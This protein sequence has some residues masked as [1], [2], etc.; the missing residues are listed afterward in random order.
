MTVVE[1]G[2]TPALIIE[3]FAVELVLDAIEAI[4]F[5]TFFE[6]RRQALPPEVLLSVKRVIR[7]LR[8]FFFVLLYPFLA[9]FEKILMAEDL[10]IMA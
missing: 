3:D 5:L 2:R 9:L 10:A 1:A 7:A 8:F 6:L 4:V